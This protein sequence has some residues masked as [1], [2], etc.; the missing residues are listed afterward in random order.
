MDQIALFRRFAAVALATM[1]AVAAVGAQGPRQRSATVPG[2]SISIM[3]GA[4]K[5]GSIEWQFG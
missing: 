4:T 5:A 2:W 1:V 3:P